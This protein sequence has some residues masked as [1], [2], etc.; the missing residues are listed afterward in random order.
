MSQRIYYLDWIRI[1]VVL[2]LIPFHT[3]MT[4]APYPWYL[5]NNEL[6]HATQA[7]VMVMDQYHMELLFLIAGAA[8]FFSL[9]A[10]SGKAY[11][12]E[13]LKRLFIPLIFG[14]LV[15]VPPC[16][17]VVAV[18]FSN[19]QESFFEWYPTFLRDSLS[20]F[21]TDFKAG[22]LWFLWY[23]VF[24]TVVLFPFFILIHRR[25]RHNLIPWLAGFFQ[26]PGALFLIVIPIALVEIYPSWI[27]TGDFQVFYYVIFFIIGFFLFSHPGF[28]RG[29][30]RCGPIAIVGAVITMTFYMLLVFPEWRSSVLGYDFW[31]TLKGEP[32]TWGYVIFRVLISFTTLFCVIGFIYLSQHFLDF[33]NR[34][35]NYGNNAVLPFYIIHSAPIALI[36]LWIIGLDMDVLPKY[37]MNT[38]FAFI[39]TIMLYELIKRTS[40]TRFL[41]G[42]RS[43]KSAAIPG[44]DWKRLSSQ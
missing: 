37:V 39:A 38:V 32:G 2:M 20:P 21:Q 4:F 23:L 17:W 28:K 5:R 10:R 16:Y 12:F 25:F 22:A 19:Y 33:T 8:T 13:R 43:K 9:G 3:A 14:M 42:M 7:L 24:Y 15:L 18:H 27:I 36:G 44:L 11:V 41:F 31:T 30:D 6:N 1:I 35:V 29:I 34:F 26:K 40:I